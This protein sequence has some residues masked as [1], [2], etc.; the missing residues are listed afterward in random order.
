M[1]VYLRERGSGFKWR[2]RAKAFAEGSL[3]FRQAKDKIDEIMKTG[4]PLT[5]ECIIRIKE[6]PVIELILVTLVSTIIYKL[7]LINLSKSRLVKMYRL[8]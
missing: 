8:S 1:V 3:S 4:A 6:R 2:N 5:D 7:P